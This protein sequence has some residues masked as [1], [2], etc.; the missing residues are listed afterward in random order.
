M[1][2]NRPPWNNLKNTNKSQNKLKKKIAL[3]F[4]QIATCTKKKKKKRLQKKITCGSRITVKFIGWT[5]APVLKWSHLHQKVH[6]MAKM[7]K[8]TCMKT[9][10]SYRALKKPSKLT[11]S[12]SQSCFDYSLAGGRGVNPPPTHLT[13]HPHAHLQS[14]NSFSPT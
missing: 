14:R 8:I 13:T 1:D 12:L 2:M 4:V 6:L 10:S 5:V 7:K 11:P 3:H 9:V